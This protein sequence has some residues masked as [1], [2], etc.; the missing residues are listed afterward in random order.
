M[1][2]RAFDPTILRVPGLTGPRASGATSSETRGLTSPQFSGPR[3]SRVRKFRGPE[4]RK[5]L[6]STGL[7]ACRPRASRILGPWGRR[8][9]GPPELRS[10]STRRKPRGFSPGGQA[11]FPSRASARLWPLQG[12]QYTRYIKNF[13]CRLRPKGLGPRSGAGEVARWGRHR[14]PCIPAVAAV[15]PRGPGSA[16][17]RLSWPAA[18]LRGYESNQRFTPQ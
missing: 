15:P 11:G 13:G 8:A 9:H 17:R 12:H 5:I 18:P 16:W 7:G 3:G 14:F 4:A 2:S 6:R 10:D 1:S